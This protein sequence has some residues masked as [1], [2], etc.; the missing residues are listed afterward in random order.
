LSDG[1]EILA[2]LEITRPGSST[3]RPECGPGRPFQLALPQHMH[4]LDAS[5]GTLGGIK[6]FE[7]QH[8]TRDA[9]HHVHEGCCQGA[10]H[11]CY[12]IEDKDVIT[13]LGAYAVSYAAE[14][15]FPTIVKTGSVCL[16]NRREQMGC[17]EILA[18]QCQD[19]KKNGN[20]VSA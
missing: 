14:D 15:K 16:E 3:V 17:G 9:P 11:Q 19:R 5:E 18:E 1:G 4:A 20:I 7:P 8:R 2:G 6:R 13:P 10:P 12:P